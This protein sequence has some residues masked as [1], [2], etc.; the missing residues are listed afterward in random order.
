MHLG[1][2]MIKQITE[3]FVNRWSGD[4]VI[5]VQDECERIRES[6]QFVDE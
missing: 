6:A 5:I 4:D 2:E 1:R 3:H